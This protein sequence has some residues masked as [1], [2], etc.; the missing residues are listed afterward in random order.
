MGLEAAMTVH[1]ACS[2]VTMPALEM[3]ILCCS[4]ASWILVL[5]ASFIWRKRWSYMF[6]MTEKGRL[7]TE[8]I[9]KWDGKESFFFTSSRVSAHLVELID[10]TDSAVGQHQRSGL[11]RPLAADRVSLDVSGQTDGRGPLT[12]G[13]HGT[14][15]HLLHVPAEKN[16]TAVQFQRR[17]IQ[18]FFITFRFGLES[19]FI[20]L[21]AFLI[22]TRV[23][24]VSS[25]WSLDFFVH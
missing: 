1:L 8:T 22:L 3:E 18:I 17:S 20:V 7:T 13:E 25:S 11:Q 15:R 19:W 5:S 9:Q 4:M 2:E 10:Q 21:H 23:Y 12:R 24:S 16:P 6:I 14:T